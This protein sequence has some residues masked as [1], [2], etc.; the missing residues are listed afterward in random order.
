[1]FHARFISG[2]SFEQP[3]SKVVCVGRN[4]AEHARELDNPIPDSPIL[5]IK[6]ETSVVSIEESFTIPAT[7][8]H[9]EAEIAIL[10][11]KELSKVKEHEAELGI[12][13]VGLALDLT[14]RD[15]QSE[16][17]QKR[18]PWEISKAFDGAC[19]LSD[20]IPYSDIDSLEKLIFSLSING[21]I[22]QQGSSSDMITP[23]IPLIMYISQFFT[24]R[25]GDIVL[26]G[27][28]KGVGCLA[29]ND[30]IELN[31]IKNLSV[32]TKAINRQA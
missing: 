30:E 13:G 23:I 2:K 17:K 9:Y 4:Y 10:I 18:H 12:A 26:T 21:E 20:F 29:I 32:H 7:D 11:G 25:A 19:P 22:K 31:L 3:I 27:T 16:L 8:C 14:R 28:P 5:F 24:L 6:P 1:M 15:L